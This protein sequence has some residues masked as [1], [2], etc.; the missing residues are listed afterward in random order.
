MRRRYYDIDK[1]EVVTKFTDNLIV[2]FDSNNL[3][4][5]IK[6]YNGMVNLRVRP[7][8]EAVKQCFNCFKFGHVKIACRAK[9]RC[10]NCSKDFHGQCD[11]IMVCCNCGGNHKLT[12]RRC[13][14]YLYNIKIKKTIAERNCFI[15]EARAINSQRNLSPPPK[16]HDEEQWPEL[17]R[18]RLSPIDYRYREEMKRSTEQKSFREAVTSTPEN[19]R[20]RDR[21]RDIEMIRENRRKFNER[22]S[23]IRERK[24]GIIIKREMCTKTSIKERKK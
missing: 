15:Q 7:F 12:N 20:T 11:D 16:R 13:K 19:S 2:T 9:K 3:P 17:R 14:E 8:V 6:L 18:D 10:N 4:N 24:I 1:K 5:E 22:P 23:E 21:S